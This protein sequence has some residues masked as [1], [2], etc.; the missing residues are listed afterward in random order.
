[1]N[2]IICITFFFLLFIFHF[3]H[4]QK[5]YYPSPVGFVNDFE[6]D[7]SDAQVKDLDN[8]VKHLLAGA[9]K[10][11]SLKGLEMAVITITPGMY[12]DEKEMSAYATKI[13]DKWG[14]GA[15]DPHRGIIVIYSKGLRK[16]AIVTGNGLDNILPAIE[17]ENIINRKM[18]E[19]YKK[20]ENYGALVVA[21]KSIAE[22]LGI[23]LN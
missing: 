7:F 17:C 11:D 19:E 22:R 21:V 9:M 23:S 3:S 13:G 5:G 20:G 12:G 16:V 2:R 10:N 14:L 8:M 6:H 4:A 15:K 18:V 1:M